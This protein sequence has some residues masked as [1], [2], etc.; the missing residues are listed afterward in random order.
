MRSAALMHAVLCCAVLG[1]QVGKGHLRGVCYALEYR[2]GTLRFKDLVGGGRGERGGWV[3]AGRLLR[4]AAVEGAAL[5][6]L[7]WAWSTWLEQP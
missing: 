2:G 6:A 3:A 5:G 1:Q 4:Q 7:W